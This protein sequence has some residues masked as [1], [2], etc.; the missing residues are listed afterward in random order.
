MRRGNPPYHSDMG[1]PK[2]RDRKRSVVTRV[3]VSWVNSYNKQ[4]LLKHLKL[5]FMILQEW[6]HVTLHLSKLR[7]RALPNE[8]PN[9]NG[10]LWVMM[11]C[12]QQR[13]II[14]NV[15]LVWGVG[16]GGDWGNKGLILLCQIDL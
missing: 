13:W 1:H 7:K 2:N 16:S 10:G 9:V 8:K 6:T 12:E 11:L 3:M 14:I 15:T 5:L 4:D